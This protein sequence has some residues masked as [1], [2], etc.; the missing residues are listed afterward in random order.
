MP[1]PEITVLIYTARDDYPYVGKAEGWHCFEPFLR[2]LADQTFRDFELVLV[3][4]LWETRSDWFKNRPQPFPVKHVP[5][6][7]NYWQERGRVGLSSQINRGFVWADGRY[8]W[9]GAENNLYPPHHLALVAELC[10]SGKVPAAWYGSADRGCLT[11]GS[12]GQL[13]Y[14]NSAHE[15][16]GTPGPCP[17]VSFNMHGFTREDLYTMDH[18][19]ARF[20]DD[21]SLVISPC[22]HQHYYGYSSV[23]LDVADAVNGFDELMDGIKSLQDCDF[24]DRI[25][26]AGCSL[27]MHRDLYVVEPPTKQESG[28]EV[29]YGGGIRNMTS[30]QCNY[31]ILMH[32]Q[33]TGRRVNTGL[34]P[35]YVEDVQERICRGVCPI[36][37]KC[38]G[39]SIGESPMYP[40]CAGEHE[41][42]AR[43]WHA[44]ISSR[45]LKSE[46]E[47]RR[48]GRAPYDKGFVQ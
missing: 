22:H 20:A 6:K 18:R 34:S 37:E 31:A 2:T 10:R 4:A 17:D 25:V 16:K 15:G 46:R 14:N 11:W 13:F 24:G 43:E 3:D 27:V 47:S 8:V 39:G 41:A 42:M 44:N 40:F 35:G 5:S 12:D 32:N 9:M 19:A 48:A 36:Q 33:L 7:P 45:D 30:F 29:G 38:K 23:P 28:T 26:H 21:T 1:A